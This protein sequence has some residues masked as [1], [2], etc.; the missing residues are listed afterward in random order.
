MKE[1]DVQS[2]PNFNSEAAGQEK[3]LQ[4]CE[5]AATEDQFSLRQAIVHGA[6]SGA[7]LVH[8]NQANLR[9]TEL[10]VFGICLLM[11][12]I[13]NTFKN[14]DV[15]VPAYGADMVCLHLADKNLWTIGKQSFKTLQELQQFHCSNC[16]RHQ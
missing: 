5:A 9:V 4:V 10:C 7:T 6:T 3:P 15:Y 12:Q 13:T 16:T 14:C 11:R 1:H 8:S 2:G